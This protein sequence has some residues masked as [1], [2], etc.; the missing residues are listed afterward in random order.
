[1]A[2]NKE[3]DFKRFVK[4]PGTSLTPGVVCTFPVVAALDPSDRV[5]AANPVVISHH[6]LQADPLQH[7]GSEPK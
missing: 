6:Q 3:Y 5:R 7:G 1:M 2:K 4:F